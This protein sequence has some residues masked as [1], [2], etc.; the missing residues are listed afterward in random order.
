MNR[1][2]VVDVVINNKTYSKALILVLAENDEDA[3]QQIKDASPH[4]PF[5]EPDKMTFVN[6]IDVSTDFGKATLYELYA[7]ST[8]EFMV[9]RTIIQ[10]TIFNQIYLP[11]M[12]CN[13]S[14]TDVIVHVYSKNKGIDYTVTD[15]V[16]VA[17]LT[18]NTGTLFWDETQKENVLS[19][20]KKPQRLS[21]IIYDSTVGVISDYIKMIYEILESISKDIIVCIPD[22]FYSEKGEVYRINITDSLEF[23]I[24]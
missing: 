22:F 4:A 9:T 15:K 6:A 23:V 12:D 14:S 7:D 1:Y 21:F 19:M 18:N 13:Q 8:I 10:T 16:H 17:T 5:L 2:F 24:I 11:V 3:V 20:F